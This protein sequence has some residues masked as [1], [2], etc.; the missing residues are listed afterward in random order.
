MRQRHRPAAVL[1][2]TTVPAAAVR[3]VRARQRRDAFRRC[4]TAHPRDGRQQDAVHVRRQPRRHAHKP[5]DG[6]CRPGWAR[7]VQHRRLER[8]HR[9]RGSSRGRRGPQAATS[10][11]E[12]S[13]NAPPRRAAPPRRRAQRQRSRGRHGRVRRGRS[14][15][16]HQAVRRRCAR[17][18]PSSAALRQRSRVHRIHAAARC[19]DASAGQPK[20]AGYA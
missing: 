2:T 10:V 9:P 1:A 7:A 18:R 3:R 4:A 13:I 6:Q 16:P 15:V 19:P 14:S 11:R 5:R 12:H 17:R 8:P 20:L